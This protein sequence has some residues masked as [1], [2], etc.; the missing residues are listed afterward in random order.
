MADKPPVPRILRVVNVLLLVVFLIGAGI[1]IRAWLGMQ[2]LTAYEST[3]GEPLFSAM[4]L[5][6]QYWGLSITGLWVMS[7][8]GLGAVGAAIAA[9]VMRRRGSAPGAADAGEEPGRA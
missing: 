1:Y 8:A 5:F 6:D 3:P 9:V 4:A 2:A 7:A